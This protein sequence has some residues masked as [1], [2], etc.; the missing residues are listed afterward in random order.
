MW[1]T[2]L[3]THLP[4]CGDAKWTHS[5]TQWPY[6]GYAQRVRHGTR[7][8]SAFRRFCTHTCSAFTLGYAVATHRSIALARFLPQATARIDEHDFTERQLEWADLGTA[9]LPTLTPALRHPTD[10]LADVL[11]FFFWTEG[12]VTRH[13]HPVSVKSFSVLELGDMLQRRLPN[14]LFGVENSFTWRCLWLWLCVCFLRL[15][16][17]HE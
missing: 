10:V 7:I 17:G 12:A 5:G 3:R 14:A 8:H 13:L 9:S 6:A 2:L 11:T 15:C 16:H 1:E 4:H